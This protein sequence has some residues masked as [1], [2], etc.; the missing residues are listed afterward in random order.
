MSNLSLSDEKSNKFSTSSLK[1]ISKVK[2]SIESKSNSYNLE[3]TNEGME[4]LNQLNTNKIG[5]ISI[6][7]PE[8]SEK[9]YFANLILGEKAAFD[10]SKSTTDIYT[11]GQPIVQGDSTEL[12]VIDTEGLYKQINSK[13]QYD[14]HTFILS[15]LSSS[16]MIYNTNETIQDCVNKFTNLAKE[17]LSCIKKINGKDL[18]S[19]DMPLVYFIL[20]NNNIDSNTANQQFRNLVKDNPIFSIFFQNYKICVLK[21]AG[22]INVDLKR[23]KSF[24]SKKIAEIGSLDEVDYKQKAKLIKDQIMNDLE[25]KKINNC[26][27][28]G[29]CLFGL[30][31]LFVDS[32][33][34]NENIILFEQFNKVLALCLSE[35]VD[36]INFNYT[37]EKLE[38]K[39]AKKIAFEETYL[40]TIKVTFTETIMEQFEKLKSTPIVKISPST[41]V[42]NNIELILHK[43]INILCQNIQS[44]VDNKTKIIND[45][46]KLEFNFKIKNSNIEQVFNEYNSFI[47]KK[48]FEPLFGKN[49]LKLQNNDKI[50]K[51]LEDKICGIISKISLIIQGNIVKLISENK[52]IKDEFDE[53]KK[54]HQKEIEKKE[55]DFKDRTINLE[56]REL[57][58]K[59]KELFIKEDLKRE[60]LKYS[61]LETRYNNFS[62]ELKEKNKQIEELLNKNKELANSKVFKNSNIYD[63]NNIQLKDLKNDYNNI[64]DIFVN[65]KILVNKLINDKDFFFENIL[66]D[67]NIGNLEK[68]YPKIFN[69]ISERETLEEFIQAFTKEKER[70]NNEIKRIETINNDLKN[71]IKDLNEKLENSKQTSEDYLRKLDTKI[72]EFNNFKANY[73]VEKNDMKEKELKFN[74]SIAECEK[75]EKERISLNKEINCLQEVIQGILSKDQKK[76]EK[77]LNDLRDSSKKNIS[78]WV[79][80]FRLKWG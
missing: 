37:S 62:R 52:K 51:I 79:N 39:M 3:V 58:I 35:I 45:M 9:S 74:L 28:D 68:K 30:L 48:I 1:L 67:K 69:L 32:L 19:T 63:V 34:K 20:H 61:Q 47:Y 18:T 55:K 25:P 77:N 59:Q 7:G 4:Y 12:L 15:C 65:Y 56:K 24:Y 17:S 31:Q 27:I 38:E 14:K 60:Q 2:Q 40:D 41:N 53:F 22:D 57:D 75:F 26:N 49:D 80:I 72:S 33:N 6:I 44:N 13:T 73:E 66:I 5:I 64:L 29:K 70:L 71:Q 76:F 43:C 8:K 10:S 50:L 78:D 21:K 16:I 46:S 11:W 36:Q 42:V 54:N 23:T